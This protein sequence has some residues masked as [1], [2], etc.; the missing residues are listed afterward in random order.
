ME[1][2]HEIVTH[3]ASTVDF[4][5][6]AAHYASEQGGTG[7]L[8]ELGEELTD[9]FENKYKDFFFD[10]EFYDYIEEFLQAAD[11]EAAKNERGAI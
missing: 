4:S 11:A 3:L 8:W 10:G 9:M 5:G 7:R 2:H 1:T 6:S